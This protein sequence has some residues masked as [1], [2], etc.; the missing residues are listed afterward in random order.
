LRAALEQAGLPLAGVVLADGSGLAYDNRVTPRLLVAALRYADGSFDFGAEFLVGLPIAGRD[1]TLKKR[2]GGAVD[3]VRA[4]TGL[5][6]R[7]TALAGLARLA[8]ESEVVFALMVNDYKSSD[9][10]AMRAVDGFVTA[11]VRS[12]VSP[13]PAP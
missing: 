10:G 6:T 13:A 5:L 7:V 1:G 12:R 8:D 2:A 9:D 4:K 3:A 11:L